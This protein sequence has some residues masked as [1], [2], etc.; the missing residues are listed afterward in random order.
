MSG[1]QPRDK[2]IER[3]RLAFRAHGYER[4][5]MATLA[6]ACDVTRRTLYNHFHSKED[7]FRGM[8]QWLH[9][10]EITE[11]LAAG[12]E[13]I[14]A[15]GSVLDAL[16]AVMETRYAVTRRGLETSPH[17]I[18]INYTAFR[19]FNDVISASAVSFQAEL[20]RF[21]EE[22]VAEGRLR[23][24]PDIT[25]AELTQL[26]A[27]GARGVNQSLPAKPAVGLPGRYRAM[28]AVILRGV[29]EDSPP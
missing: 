25:P 3:L 5:T 12:R 18:E 17:A 26:L 16:V 19:R 6:D 15:G 4:V 20:T 7:A 24:R 8:L 23:L 29:S 9:V 11:G 1:S 28:Y 2:L 27:D 10:R 13:V 14:D 22:L 21:L